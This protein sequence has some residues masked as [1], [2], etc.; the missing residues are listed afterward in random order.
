MKHVLRPLFDRIVIKELE[1]ALGPERART[2]A[3]TLRAA[4]AARGAMALGSGP[5]QELSSRRR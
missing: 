5:A 1:Q 2:A 3:R 4:L